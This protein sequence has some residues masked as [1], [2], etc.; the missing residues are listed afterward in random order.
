MRDLTERR[1][2]KTKRLS[3]LVRDRKAI[4]FFSGPLPNQTLFPFHSAL[5]TI[6][7]TSENAKKPSVSRQLS[8][9]ITTP[10]AV[11]ATILWTKVLPVA[12]SKTAAT[13]PVIGLPE[14]E[15]EIVST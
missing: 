12:G 11:L 4:S 14:R 5:V 3:N 1:R 10:V 13:S 9:L 6:P 2:G 8:P 7:I 15:R